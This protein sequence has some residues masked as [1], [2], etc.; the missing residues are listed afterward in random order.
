M[1]LGITK[2]AY[3]IPQ[4]PNLPAQFARI[5]F[6]HVMF[7]QQFLFRKFHLTNVA[8]HRRIDD[9]F[10]LHMQE[11]LHSVVSFEPT[12]EAFDRFGDRRFRGADSPSG[13]ARNAG[14]RCGRDGAEPL[15]HRL[16]RRRFYDRR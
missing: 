13:V 5:V 7:H 14:V 10:F 3:T 6:L 2:T 8:F 1:I 4:F 12:E 16:F 9:V 11:E 15:H